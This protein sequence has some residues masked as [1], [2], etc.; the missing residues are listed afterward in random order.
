MIR[1]DDDSDID[2]GLKTVVAEEAISREG[3]GF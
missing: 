3:E 1:H 2:M